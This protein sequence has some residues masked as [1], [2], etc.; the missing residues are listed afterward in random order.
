MNRALNWLLVLALALALWLRDPLIGLLALLLALLAGVTALWERYA[1]AGVTYERRVGARQLF[2]G[3]ETELVVAIT[4]AKPLS[5]P[6]LRADDEFPAELALARGRLAESYK[7]NRRLLTNLLP[8]RFYERVYRHYHLR[9]AKRGVLAFGPVRLLAGDLFGLRRQERWLEQVDE[10]VVYPRVVPWDA[11]LMPAGYP[12]G[13][14]L[15]ARRVVDDPLRVTGA[16]P[17]T[18]GDNPR[19]LHWK[20]TACRGEL[21]TRT[22]EPGATPRTAIFLD[23]QTV[24]GAPG[25]IEAYVEYAIV[26]AASLARCLLD[27][28]QAVGLFAN[29]L[30]RNSRDLVRLPVS[31]HPDQWREILDALAR[32]IDLPRMPLE[33]LLASEMPALPYG[34]AVV[35]I[36]AVPDVSLYAALLDL[37]RAGHP[38]FLLAIGDTAPADVPEV[39]A[40]TWL[41][42][43][44]A[45][46]ALVAASGTAGGAA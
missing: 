2:V 43:R 30:L 9:A 22:F 14:R 25:T 32:A 5:L 3:D 29:A 18:P 6:W 15:A 21:Q 38:T 37:Q 41:G 11:L 33:R 34:A 45:Y 44:D 42:G 24:R 46:V 28:R 13:D 39:L 26:V 17:Y 35:A 27:G 23:V 8:L 7:A 31:R 36:S 12:S 19:Y 10:L 4:N 40:C 1:L 16:R 20:A